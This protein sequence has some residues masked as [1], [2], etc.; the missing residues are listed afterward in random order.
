MQDRRLIIRPATLDDQPEIA[1]LYV[2]LRDHHRVLEPG[3]PRYGTDDL[4]WELE[5]RGALED[6]DIAVLAAEAGEGVVGFV[7]LR[8]EPKPWGLSCEVHTLVVEAAWRGAGTGTKLMAA[9]EAHAME[10]GARG[11]RV[12]VLL[13]NERGRAFYERLGYEPIAVRYGKPIGSDAG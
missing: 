3:N 9:A 8:Y 12:Q 11:M 10:S 2:E 13:T 1:R 6:P 5:A 4:R 7:K